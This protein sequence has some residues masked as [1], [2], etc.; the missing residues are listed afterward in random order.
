[1]ATILF[2][3][4]VGFTG[5]AET[6]DPELVQALVGAA[7]DR[8]SAEVARYEGVVEKF[9]GD[10]MLAL[11]GI[12]SAHEDDPERAVRAALEMQA[13]I[14]EQATELRA[15]GR[16]ELQLRIGI[17]TGEVLVDLGRVTGERDRMVTGD[18]VNTSARLQAVSVPG[19]IVVGPGTYAA[20]R[21]VVEY[22]E[23]DAL[24]LKGKALPVPSWRAVRVKARR[25][26]ARTPLGLEAPL[27]GRDEELG[28]LKETVRRVTAER[29]PHLVTVLAAAGV[30]KSRLAWELE[31]YL[32]GLPEPYHWRKGR[33]LSYGQASY[34]GLIEIIRADC[35]VR[36]D[37]GDDQ[38]RLRT[39][40]RL[41]ELGLTGDEQIGRALSV[42]LGTTAA[43]PPAR[44]DLF[45]GWR[46]YFEAISRRAPLVLVLEDIHWA[47]EGFLDFLDFLARWAESPMLLLGLARH[48]LVERRPGWGG[49]IPNSATIV[50]EPLARS[51]NEALLDAL[52]P[53][54][55]PSNLKDRIIAV[56]E[57]NPL[58]CEEVVRMLVDR[59][60]ARPTD[61]GWE[62]V[63]P[64]EELEIPGSIQALLAAR[65]DSLPG[66]EKRVTQAAAVVGRIFWDAVLA[67]V[68]AGASP[69]LDRLLRGLR[70]KELV[71]TRDPSTLSGAREYGF[72]HVLIRD[73]AYE[74]VPKSERAEKH[75]Q[76]AHWAEERL[77]ARED[78][79][80]ELL[81]SH[82]RSALAYREEAL[83]GN[84]GEL[85][86][87]RGRVLEYA[88]RAGRRAA[89][90][91]QAAAAALWLR[92]GLEQARKLELDPLE[93]AHIALE[94]LDVAITSE[95]TEESL[96]VGRRAAEELE[97]TG[98]D[99]DEALAVLSRLQAHVGF[100][101]YGMGLPD[102][103]RALLEAALRRVEEGP[104]SQARAHLLWRLGWLTWRAFS[105]ADAVPILQR[106]VADA[107]AAGAPD[108]ERLAV[109][110][111][112][113]ALEYSG[114]LGDGLA[115]MEQSMDMARAAGDQ[116]LLLRCYGNVPTLLE[117]TT[118]DLDRAN[119]IE[120]EGLER[121]RRGGHRF[122]TSFLAGNIGSTLGNR[123]RFEEG[124]RL[125]EESRTVAAELGDE[126]LI[127]LAHGYT[128]IH[129][130]RFGRLAEAV[131]PW[132]ESARHGV[133]GPQ[134]TGSQA[135]GDAMLMWATDPRGA[136]SALA[137]RLRGA[138]R[139]EVEARQLARMARRTGQVEE[140][141]ATAA[142]LPAPRGP[143][144]TEE[145]RWRE[146]LLGEPSEAA[147]TIILEVA[148]RYRAAAYDLIYADALAD[149]AYLARE[150]GLASADELAREAAQ[151]YARIAAVPPLDRSVQELAARVSAPS[152]R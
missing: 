13:A 128:A 140:A 32:D 42:L 43:S 76:V 82:Y 98:R 94:Y 24:E 145:A 57:G 67:H 74:S 83:A 69:D 127:A 56:A 59:G 118:W 146:A 116:G 81:A 117:A 134:D 143:R 8:L 109:H 141:R 25:G 125:L 111:L 150:I 93:R 35:G 85:A 60:I 115:L 106:A 75:L 38:A 21:G 132:A 63:A 40:S 131:E 101:T 2:A 99:D 126:N 68:I 152:G 20:T 64:V 55:L 31:K 34:G 50:L 9:A 123:G 44:E 26:G 122:F 49:G 51:E 105:P 58:F 54:T 110:D 29:R 89:G 1:V 113:I 61:A 151:V 96:A 36:D 90:L 148:E 30:G 22:E 16:P 41:A 92:I 3:D 100:F 10:A 52:L 144:P 149:A 53:G 138:D 108:T 104:P 12:P 28:L 18:P 142:T 27:I 119:A 46:R 39:E 19:T 136:V 70:V 103:A 45:E 78:E 97:A 48:E 102:E 139:A 77:A 62:L 124:M 7:F 14:A 84:E 147:V 87:L 72:R 47:D 137:E 130:I 88:Q 112:G 6:H 23:L 65:L 17:E 135:Y 79:L 95:P 73:V 15:R 121:A 129:L 66:P 37:D 5:L 120:L 4:I 91:W 133:A 107:R 71:V 86:E 11:F 33:S 114:R 80:V